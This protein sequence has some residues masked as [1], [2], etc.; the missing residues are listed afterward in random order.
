[1]AG[2]IG[3]FLDGVVIVL[4]L[5][6]L[7]LVFKLERR[8]AAVRQD[9]TAIDSSAMG[10]SEATRL[11]EAAALR[12]RASAESAGR[13]VAERIAKAE[14]MRDDLRYLVERAESMA[15]RLDGLVR[16][17]RPI[18]QQAAPPEEAPV[19][20]E[21]KPA[22]PGRSNAERE[23]LKALARALPGAVR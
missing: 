1:M 3:L 20:S 9:R 17:A 22:A 2:W 11:A 5:V 23:L 10:L 6:A 7:P 19:P 12:L 14:P 18:V 16:A 21:A 13:Q 4:L 15:D 8:L